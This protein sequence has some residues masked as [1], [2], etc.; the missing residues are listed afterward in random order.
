VA[1]V[2]GD[3][4]VLFGAEGLYGSTQGETTAQAW[5]AHLQANYNITRHFYWYAGVRHDDDRFSGFAFQEAIKTGAGYQFV[6]TNATKLTAQIG[7]GYR[8]LRPEILVK[9]DIGA[10][11]S[12]TPLDE[13]SDAVFDGALNFEH[14]FNENTKLLAGAT[15]QSGKENTLTTATLSLQVKMIGRLALAAGYQLTDNSNPPQGS[16]RRDSLT[17]LNLVYEL[18]NEKLAPE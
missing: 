13:Q 10:I 8:R 5:D 17:T 1:H 16:R 7:A 6:Q 14:A 12:R 3:W 2:T 11:I 15:V 18:K 4:K 9:D